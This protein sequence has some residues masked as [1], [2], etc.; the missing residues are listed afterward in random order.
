MPEIVKDT[1][2]VKSD[3]I[4]PVPS[5]TYEHIF[6]GH[7][8]HPIHSA[9]ESNKAEKSYWPV[10]VLLFSFILLVYLRVNSSRRFFQIIRAFFSLSYTRQL[11]RE[12]YRLNKGTSIALIVLFIIT[13]SIFLYKLN[14]YYGFVEFSIPGFPS[15]L[16]IC[17]SILF[18]Y[19]LKILINRLLSFL[20]DETE[21]LDEYIFNVFMMNKATGFFLFPVVIALQYI[22]VD[23]HYLFVC[24]LVIAGFFYAIRLFRGFVIGYAG[25]GI[26]I[27]HLFLYLC[28][29]EILPLVVLIK[30]LVSKI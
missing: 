15:F 13:A 11:V 24:G 17:L 18:V 14:S 16:V 28:T 22:K 7:L 19:S 29:L 23:P 12:E 10:F 9:A 25:R 5:N 1:L 8:L 20:V 4:K 6:S 2:F 3:S 30:L 26:S 27:F 21:R